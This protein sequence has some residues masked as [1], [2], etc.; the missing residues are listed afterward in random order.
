MPA[1]ALLRVGLGV[2]G[3]DPLALHQPLSFLSFPGLKPGANEKGMKQPGW[4][5]GVKAEAAENEP[6]SKPVK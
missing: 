2:Q 1:L 4:G 5:P 6:G 3:D